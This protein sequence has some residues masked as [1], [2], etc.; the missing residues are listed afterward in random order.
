MAEAQPTSI[1]ITPGKKVVQAT[2][3]Y[4]AKAGKPK[5]EMK[6]IIECDDPE[7]AALYLGASQNNSRNQDPGRSV[8]IEVTSGM[9]E[10]NSPS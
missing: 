9:E 3:K 2:L 5:A 6:I 4:P 1:N 10:I 8:E 7:D